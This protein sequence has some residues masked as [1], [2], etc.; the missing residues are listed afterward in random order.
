[1]FGDDGPALIIVHG[2]FG[3]IANWRAV[4]REL[5]KNFQVYVIDQ[6]NHGESL[7]ADSMSYKDMA[8]DL[9]EFI[10]THK[11]EDFT[12][13]GHS[14][15]GK[16]VMTYALSGYA[17]AERMTAIVVL[18]IA[19]EIYTHSHAPFLASMAEIDLGLVTSRAEVEKLLQPAIPDNSTRLFL[20]QSLERQDG[21]FRWKLNLPVL[22]KYMPD[23]VGFPKKMLLGNSKSVQSLFLYGS[24]SDYVKPEMHSQIK[25]YF[26]KAEFDSVEA[27]HWLHVEQR[28][29]M[30]DSI[31]RFLNV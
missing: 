24:Q 22:H 5:S 14:M 21:Q 26:P 15:G 27:G 10:R 19:P 17:S 1:M 16:A 29:P 2:L 4:A 28:L 30:I 6:R 9:D 7:N 25:K 8:D 3:S 18:D 11:L 23:I 12:L 13:C 31:N 20:M